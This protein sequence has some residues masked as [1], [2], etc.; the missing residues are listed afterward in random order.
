VKGKPT[1]SDVIENVISV[2]K[3]RLVLKKLLDSYLSEKAEAQR[4]NDEHYVKY[5]DSACQTIDD[6]AADLNISLEVQ[7]GEQLEST[8]P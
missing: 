7:P 3:I 5:W 6:M 2:T 1:M 8:A 4:D